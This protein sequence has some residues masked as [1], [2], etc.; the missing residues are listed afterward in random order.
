MKTLEIETLPCVRF[1]HVYSAEFYSTCFS[2]R[3]NCIEVTYISQGSIRIE[4][5]GNTCTALAGDIVCIPYCGQEVKINTDSFHEHRTVFAEVEWL[6]LDSYQKGL[7]LPTVTPSHLNTKAARSIIEQLIH[8]Q[9]LFKESQARGATKFLNLLFEIDLCNRN[10]VKTN[11]PSEVLYAMRAKEYIHQ[12]L[13][14]P[15]TQ[16]EV[17]EQLSISPEYL[18]SVFKKS[19][20]ISIMKYINTEKMEGIRVLMGKEHLHLYEAALHFGYGD[21]N[22]VSRLF[23]KYYGYS[24]TEKT[25]IGELK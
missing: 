17:A 19:E 23:K 24:I 8:D 16:R 13:H 6:E 1:A 9:L 12:N 14:R 21:P 25:K 5:R 11:L 2:N 20:G 4:D 22:Y 10:A 7:C 3:N 18:C 15:I